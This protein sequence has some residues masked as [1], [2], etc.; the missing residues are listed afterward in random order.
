[1]SN[2]SEHCPLA[3][4]NLLRHAEI[5][6]GIGQGVQMAEQQ[7]RHEFSP[8]P[9]SARLGHVVLQYEIE[10]LLLIDRRKGIFRG[11]GVFL[12]RIIANL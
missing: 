11:D 7:Q 6:R 12:A 5:G 4:A 9:A 1:M 8:C 10:E 3:R 2:C